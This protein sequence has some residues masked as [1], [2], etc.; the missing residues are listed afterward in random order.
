MPAKDRGEPVAL[1][2]CGLKHAPGE[3]NCGV[4]N[5]TSIKGTSNC[6]AEFQEILKLTLKFF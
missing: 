1:W 4:P 2:R 3:W 6:L 5:T